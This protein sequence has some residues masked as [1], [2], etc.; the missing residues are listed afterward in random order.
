MATSRLL[1]SLHTQFELHT[2]DDKT[3]ANPYGLPSKRFVRIFCF[4]L[5]ILVFCLLFGT[6]VRRSPLKDNCTSLRRSVETG[7]RVHCRR[8]MCP[9]CC[10][11][12]SYRAPCNHSSANRT[13]HCV[14]V[15][16]TTHSTFLPMSLVMINVTAC[17]RDRV[18]INTSTC[19]LSHSLLSR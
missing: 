12:Y 6:T 17:V 15:P 16:H 11:C 9:V 10:Y 8:R 3:S 2:A 18:L 14:Y 1:S 4:T 7:L 5:L 19:F 13:Y